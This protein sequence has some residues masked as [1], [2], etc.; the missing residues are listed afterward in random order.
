MISSKNEMLRNVLFAYKLFL[1]VN[2]HERV[3]LKAASD[4]YRL[5]RKECKI[6][7]LALEIKYFLLVHRY[8]HSVKENEEGIGKNK[9]EIYCVF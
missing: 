1:Y 3:K 6:S 8:S 4:E 2:T 5:I 7:S 9:F